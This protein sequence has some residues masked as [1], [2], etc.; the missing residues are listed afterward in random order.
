[1]IASEKRHRIAGG[2]IEDG[3]AHFFLG[4]R[5][6]LDVEPERS[7]GANQR[8]DH[9]RKANPR[10][11]HSIGTK[12]D[13]FVVRGKPPEDEQNGGEQAPRNCKDE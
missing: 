3:A 13:Q 12:R 5:R 6:D 9:Q 2:E 7:G 4:R 10:D 11:A 8:D 1:M